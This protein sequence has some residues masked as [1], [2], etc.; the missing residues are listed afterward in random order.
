MC[1]KHERS[2]KD[3]DLS[4]IDINEHSFVIKAGTELAR[5][6]I[7]NYNP[8]IPTGQENRY[9]KNPHDVS[10]NEYQD[11]F[12]QG[13]AI[14]CGTGNTCLSIQLVTAYREVLKKRG[15]LESAIAYKVTFLKDILAIDTISICLSEGVNPAPKEDDDFWHSFYGPPI[16][17]QAL[18]CRSAQDP[19]GENIIIFP[20]NI[21]DYLN[22]LTYKKCSKDEIDSAIKQL[23]NK[24]AQ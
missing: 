9:A 10:I 19:D 21:P 6:I 15:S 16:K 8:L 22:S 24:P 12:W 23:K 14:T 5:I 3:I 18:R 17:A 11:A 13:Q 7:G 4:K 1:K 2:V 20:D